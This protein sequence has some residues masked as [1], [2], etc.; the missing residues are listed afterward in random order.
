MSTQQEIYA[1]GSENRPPMLTKANYVP[2]SSRL[3]HYAKIKPNGKLIYNFIINGPYVRRMIPKLGDPDCEV[4]VAETFHAQ[5]DDE[6]TKKEVKQIEAD[7]QAIQIILMGLPEYIYV[8]AEVN[9]LRAERLARAHDPLDF[10]WANGN[11]VAARAEGNLNRNNGNQ[12]RCYNCRGLGHY[13]RNCTAKPRK[14]DV[15]FLQTQR[16]L[17]DLGNGSAEE[18][19]KFVR[20]FKSLVKEADESLA[21]NK[22]LEFEIE[23]LLRAVASQD[24]MSIINKYDKISCDKA[25][26]DMQQKI[27]WLQAQLGDLK[28]V[29]NTA[30]TR[31]PQPRSNTKN[32]R[33]PSASKSR[34]IKNKEVEV[35]EHHRNLMLSKNKKHMSSECNNIKLAIRNDKS[36]VVYVMLNQ[37]L[38]LIALKVVQIYLWCVDSGCSK[39]MTG[40]LKLLINFIWKFLGTVRFG[41][42]HVTAILGYGDLQWGNILITRVYLVEGLWHNLFSVKQFC[43]SDLEVIFR[44]NTCFVRNLERVDLLKGNRT[45]NLYTINLHEIASTSPIY[46]M[47]HATSTKSWLWHQRLSHLNFNT[48]NDL[49]NNY[50]VTGLPKFKYHKEHLCPSC[51]QGKIKKV[52][53]PP[54]PVPNSKQRLHLLHMDLFGLMRVK[55]INVLKEYFDSVG[56]SHQASSVRTPQQNGF[57][58]RRNQMLVEAARTMLIFS[59]AP[60]FLWAEAIATACYTQNCSIIHRR[61][62]KTPYELINGK[63]LDISFLH[64]FGALCYPKNDREDIGKL[65]TKG[66]IGFF[67]GYSA[68]SSTYRFYN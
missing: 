64:V 41:N 67:I 18:A 55:S 58:E 40:N 59:R 22:A 6:L 9:E 47:A 60:L 48:I 45:T 21:K 27:K 44:W 17:R 3:L 20:D 61:F 35:E 30:K 56:I 63:K 23:R 52:S 29:D 43:D 2:W 24:I 39:H 33:V 50:I 34:C 5:T 37:R 31:R 14:K 57:V 42:D 25:Y 11:V 54:K 16:S 68:T 65:G 7:D 26:N 53:H 62:N 1:A 8:V 13:A 15:A 51:E 12:I 32:D 19:A 49:A 46:L 28:G 38:S 4:P 66:D 36:E 10:D